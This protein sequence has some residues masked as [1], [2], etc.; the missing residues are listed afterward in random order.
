MKLVRHYPRA[1]AVGAAFAFIFVAATT[2]AFV[3]TH[4]RASQTPP[5]GPATY[6]A[7]ASAPT[8][9]P[10]QNFPSELK[11]FGVDLASDA[12]LLLGLDST[13]LYAAA[14]KD[15]GHLCLV[16]ERP[17]LS[18][19]TCTAR[20]LVTSDDVIWI[21]HARPGGTYEVYGLAP[22]GT[23]KASANGTA[24]AAVSN[25]AFV[26][27]NIPDSVTSFATTGHHGTKEVTVGQLV[28]PG[29]TIADTN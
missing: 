9:L 11:R 10:A 5:A 28:P 29:V 15:G 18:M 14:S 27:H 3:S 17:A 13:Q 1:A 7:L 4:S 24:P 25:N 26:L 20:S 6:A 8:S 19:S 21:S 16:V 2:T 22:D 12:H 23:T